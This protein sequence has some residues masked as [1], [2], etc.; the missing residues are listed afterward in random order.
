[1]GTTDVL[2]RLAG[3]KYFLPPDVYER[4]KFIGSFITLGETVLDVGGSLSKL[5]EFCQTVP[6]TVDVKEPTDIIYDGKRIPVAAKSFDVVT[7]V[8]VLEHIPK[9]QRSRFLKELVRVAKHKVILSAPY[10]T[11]TH[12]DYEKKTLQ[13]YPVPFLKEHVALGLP[14][15]LEI[16][17]LTKDYQVCFYYS[18]DLRLTSTLFWLHNLEFK[19][20]LLDLPLFFLKLKINFLMNLLGYH[21]LVKRKP[22]E[23]TNRFYFVLSAGGYR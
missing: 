20:R 2:I 17:E 22:G 21:F 10:G 3:F 16:K 7:A 23:L 12:L 14:T 18:G 6:T 13:R 5:G 15:P 4:H 9:E 8:D 19:K 1:M 11:K